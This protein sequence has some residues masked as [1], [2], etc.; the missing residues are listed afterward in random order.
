MKVCVGFFVMDVVENQCYT[1][2]MLNVTPRQTFKTAT[3]MNVQDT[4]IFPILGKVLTNGISCGILL[5]Q[6]VIEV[7]LL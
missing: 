1:E 3:K 7:R 4:I 5:S 2:A 6:I